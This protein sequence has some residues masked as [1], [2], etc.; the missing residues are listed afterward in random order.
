M[1]PGFD[2]PARLA[3]RLRLEGAPHLGALKS[4]LFNAFR[5]EALH[6]AFM[7]PC[8]QNLCLRFIVES[9]H[10]PNETKGNNSFPRLRTP[11]RNQYENSSKWY[12]NISWN[13]LP[14]KSSSHRIFMKVLTMSVNGKDFK[15]FKWYFALFK[16]Y[17][18]NYLHRDPKT[19]SG[20]FSIILGRRGGL[21]VSALVSGSSSPVSSPG[22][23]HI[24]VFLSKTFTES[25]HAKETG[26]S[27]GLMGHLARILMQTWPYLSIILHSFITITMKFSFVNS[28]EVIMGAVYKWFQRAYFLVWFRW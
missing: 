1:F 25:L 22:Q 7:P 13:S 26:I 20:S 4:F 2:S 5:D 17:Y 8:Y 12:L 19:I 6:F 3:G 9:L 18:L 28:L 10:C 15:C 16:I 24:V 27:S 23:G 11:E 21:M 14:G